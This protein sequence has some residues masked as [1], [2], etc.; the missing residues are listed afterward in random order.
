VPYGAL[1]GTLT[2][3]ALVLLTL[4][5][6]RRPRPLAG[7]AYRVASVYNEA[8]FPFI[9]LLAIF[10]AGPLVVGGVESAG[11]WLVLGLTV[12]V[13]LGFVIIAWRGARERP[14][15]ERALD[16][17]LG[18]GWLDHV[19]PELVEGIR[20]G[21]PLARILSM[22]FVFRPAKVKRVGNLSYGDAGRF[23]L[24]DVYH[25]R[26]LPEDAPM[27][28]HF[29]GGGF[30]GGHKSFES[31]ALLFRLASQGWVTISA[32]YRLRPQ[33]NFFDHLIDVKKVI[34]WAREHGQEYGADPSTLLLCGGSAGG[35]LSSVAALSQNDP[36]YQPGFEGADTSVTA[37]ASL[38]GW[39]G[40]YWEMGGPTSEMGVLGHSAADAPPFFIAH[41][42][43]DTLAMIEMAQRFVSHLRAGSPHPVVFVQLPHGQHAFDL[44][45]SFRFSAVV[46][47]I[48]A[49]AAWVRSSRSSQH[50]GDPSPRKS[51]R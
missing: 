26:D 3:G 34:A 21:P 33:A 9:Y 41:G 51:R 50:L 5:A 44:F 49:F 32:N 37:V 18:S 23:N 22:P 35:H 48:E 31:R 2:F 25:R 47:G 39:Y 38:Y 45:H 24:L 6:P 30:Y 15:V 17:G 11:E 40:G 13:I 12:L 14:I 29:H 8:P 19:R 27:M 4:I 20:Q 42:V 7:L 43:E 10:T 46:D 16:E 1:I 28:I 36:R